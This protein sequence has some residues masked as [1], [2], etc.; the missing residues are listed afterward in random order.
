M[1]T[2]DSRDVGESI[3][4]IVDAEL[5]CMCLS[6]CILFKF[7]T[8]WFLRFAGYTLT[9]LYRSHRFAIRNRNQL[10]ER[11]AEWHQKTRDRRP[12]ETSDPAAGNVDECTNVYICIYAADVFG[13]VLPILLPPSARRDL[14]CL[15]HF[16]NNP[17][18]YLYLLPFRYGKR[19]ELM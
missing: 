2:A 3:P 12:E 15:L 1:P 19:K 4:G 11:R 5:S 7:P 17:G 6:Y 10:P 14:N 9:Y 13:V 18:E 16:N 8:V